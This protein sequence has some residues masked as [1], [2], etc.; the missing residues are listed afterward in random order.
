[1]SEI[2]YYR[3]KSTPS[4]DQDVTLYVN[5]VEVV[6]KSIVLREWCDGS[7]LIK[8]LNKAGQYRFF[9]FNQYWE[10]SDKAKKIGKSNK[11]ITS[12]LTSKSS[13]D[14]MGYKNTRT[15]TCVADDV[16]QAQ[17]DILSDLWTSP[18][19]LLYVGDHVTYDIDDWIEVE[20]ISKNP[21]NKIRK[22]GSTDI[23]V[24]I[25]LPEWY[26]ITLL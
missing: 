7:K 25:T 21:I 15:I 11:I 5:G 20:A 23:S 8:F 6:A 9:A 13:T 1:M 24:S 22:G 16:T 12:L 19:V 17:L 10:S 26:S 3:H 18:K 14:N 4:A 2:G